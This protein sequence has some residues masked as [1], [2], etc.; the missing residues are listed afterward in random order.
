M[1]AATCVSMI[2]S[3]HM[4]TYT[5]TQRCPSGNSGIDNDSGVEIR[6]HGP[7]LRGREGKG[8]RLKVSHVIRVGRLTLVG[9]G[10]ITAGEAGASPETLGGGGGGRVDGGQRGRLGV[11]GRGGGALSCAVTTDT[12]FTKLLDGEGGG[13]GKVDG[14]ETD[15][16]LVEDLEEVKDG[17]DDVAGADEEGVKETI[18]EEIIVDDKAGDT[19]LLGE[20]GDEADAQSEVC[21]KF[22]GHL[23]PED[24]GTSG[25]ELK[26]GKAGVVG[27][28]LGAKDDASGDKVPEPDEGKGQADEIDGLT[29]TWIGGSGLEELNDKDRGGGDGGEDEAGEAHP[30][31]RIGEDIKGK[32]LDDN[33]GEDG[34]DLGEGGSEAEPMD[35]ESGGTVQ[36]DHDGV[37]EV[38]E[39]EDDAQGGDEIGLCCGTETHMLPVVE[40]FGILGYEFPHQGL[41]IVEDKD[42][43]TS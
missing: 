36:E 26:G 37:E 20:G 40:I 1:Q 2:G 21:C 35:R 24:G 34:D 3:K 25:E 10:E 31:T 27:K 16:L 19:T 13:D 33:G 41:L 6:V 43:T 42:S 29:V 18:L 12:T 15:G 4:H 30:I 23:G 5:H 17:T 22:N 7:R 38:T 14:V 32:D 28:F 9:D 11:K 39:G 8:R